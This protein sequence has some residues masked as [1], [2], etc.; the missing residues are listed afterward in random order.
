MGESD[1][2]IALESRPEPMLME[3]L[4]MSFHL[5]ATTGG[6]N[7]AAF[8]VHEKHKLMSFLLREAKEFLKD[9]DD[10]AHQ[11]NWVIPNDAQPWTVE[12][13]V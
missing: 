11:V 7:C 12:K 1:L 8:V 13:F 2:V 5:F 6:Y 4:D 9:K 3:L 10:V